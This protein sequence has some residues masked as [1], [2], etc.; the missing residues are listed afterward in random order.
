MRTPEIPHSWRTKEVTVCQ[1][2]QFEWV[3][4]PRCRIEGWEIR[5]RNP[6][7]ALEELGCKKYTRATI[8]RVNTIYTHTKYKLIKHTILLCFTTLKLKIVLTFKNLDHTSKKTPHF[9]IT[10]I[11]SL[12]LFNKIIPVYTENHTEPIHTKCSI[13]YRLL[14]QMIHMV[15]TQLQGINLREQQA[16]VSLSSSSN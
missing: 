1:L 11:S 14:K 6:L 12:M 4:M 2:L 5:S 16:G 9:T 10:K 8:T 7:K 13:T 3:T 15:I